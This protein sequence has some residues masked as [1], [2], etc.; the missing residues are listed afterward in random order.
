MRSATPATGRPL[1]PPGKSLPK[2]RPAP[3]T[4]ARH[5]TP[6]AQFHSMSQ[7]HIRMLHPMKHAQFNRQPA[8][9][10]IVVSPTKQTPAPQFNRQL[11]AT[12][13]IT[14]RSPQDASG[15]RI[16]QALLDTNGRLRQNNNSPNSFKTNDR[17]NS[18]SIQTA[19]LVAKRVTAYSLSNRHSVRLEIA[20]NPTKTHNLAILIDTKMRLL[21]PACPDGRVAARRPPIQ[22]YYAHGDCEPIGTD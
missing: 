18:Y 8:R 10:E 14:A 16:T 11:F 7:C 4:T 6:A 9:L 21:H 1:P 3:P 13:R 2:N 15:P 19:P 20:K 17:V 5:P 12:P 22:A